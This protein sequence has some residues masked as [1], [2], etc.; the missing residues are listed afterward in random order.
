MRKS[1]THLIIAIA[2]MIMVT[3]I[4]TL[5]YMNLEDIKPMDALYFTIITLSTV[6][7]G[8][9]Y[10]SSEESKI[11]TILLIFIGVSVFFYTIGAI[12]LNLIEGELLDVFK[13]RRLKEKIKKMK[14][15]VILCGH[16]D[17]GTSITEKLSTVV[18]IEKDEERF[19]ELIE[20][21]LVGIHG[22]S[23]NTDTLKEAGIDRARAIIIA[24]NSDPEALYTILTAKEL[25]PEIKICARANEKGSA[26]RMRRAGADYVIC[27]PDVG[28][29]ELI[30]ALEK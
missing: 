2:V 5:G 16:G 3:L 7:Y 19:N 21:G 1:T 4:G 29:R 27:L 8:D 13:L 22:D 26:R 9:I 23:T 17:V 30:R 15:H 18:V 12:A 24:L 14:N 28:S 20:K 11:F 10:P 6:G 25:N